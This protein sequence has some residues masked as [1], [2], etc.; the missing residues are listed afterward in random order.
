MTKVLL[1]VRAA[2]YCTAG[3]HHALR[4]A[5]R[6]TIRFYA[7]FAIIQHPEKGCILFD[8]GYTSRF[9]EQTRSFPNSIYARA[10]A[11]SVK[12]E[13]EAVNQLSA[14][15]VRAEEVRYI[16]VSHFHADHIG[17]LRD[18][19]NAE[20]ICSKR[21]FESIRSK[22]GWSAV[23]QGFLPGHLPAD[24]DQR[25]RL[26]D[27]EEGQPH[28]LLG[29]GVDVFGDGSIQL[30]LLEGHA[31][32]QMGALVNTASKKMFLIADAAWLREHYESEAL[33]HGI[34]RLFFD[35]W[36]NYTDTLAVLRRY[37][38]ANPDVELIACHCRATYERLKGKRF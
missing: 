17:G 8:T 38:K 13:E 6:E 32:G 11:V 7:T 23:K 33:P 29:T 9:Y 31:A 15:G 26:I 2:G 28:A 4:G 35:S 21:A 16:I 10:T 5:K 20:F 3:Q 37:H 36:K 12:K 14:M 25:L 27:F 34:V 22:S 18:F 30:Y 1:E 24:F 19:P